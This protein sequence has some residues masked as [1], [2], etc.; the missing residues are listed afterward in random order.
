MTFPIDR[1]PRRLT[2][3]A[4][5]WQDYLARGVDPALDANDKEN[6]GQDAERQG[7]YAMIGADALRLVVQAL[8]DA[9]KDVPAR[10]LDF[11]CGSG[12]VTRHLSAFFPQATVGACDLYEDHIN[13]CARQFG[14][15][16]F[17]SKENL[18]DLQIG[19]WDLIFCGSLL[20]HLPLDHFQAALRFMIRSLSD[21]GIAVVTI[22]G[23][24]ALHIQA[25]KWKLIDDRL[26]AMAE[27]DLHA[28]GFGFVDYEQD[29]RATSFGKPAR[30][31]VTLASAAWM[32]AE[33]TRHEDI[34]V[35]GFAERAWDDHQD[36]V[37]FGK[38]G[39]NR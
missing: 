7:H 5:L 23:R 16:P 10:I 9:D 29:F 32:M 12:R 1:F 22:E 33:L 30:Y 11:P 18:D 27:R 39:V 35:H 21:T 3:Y 19:T 37:V 25:H 13:F 24:H 26:F 17:L 4:A 6:V 2:T 8:I 38:P 15:Q 28:T 14:V 34:R 31:G 20:T 36:V